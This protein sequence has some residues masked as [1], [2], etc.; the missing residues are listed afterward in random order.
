MN[1]KTSGRIP[2]FLAL[3]VLLVLAPLGGDYLLGI[4]S[5]ILIFAIFAMSLNLIVGYT[6]LLSFGHA[7]FFGVATYVVIGLG[8]H[9]GISGW[10]GAIAGVLASTALAAFIGMFCIRVK[11]IPFLMLTMAFSQLLFATALKWRS[12]TGGTDGLIGFMPPDFF[13]WNMGS[14]AIA[15]YIVIVI[16]FLSV[17]IFLWYL[18]RSP[19][20][21][22]FIG[23]RDNEQRMRAIG[24]P[25]QRFKLIAFTIAGCLA[26][27]GGSLYALFNSYVSSD[28]LH[29]HLSGDAMIMVI[30]GGSG[31]VFG[32]AFGAALFLLLKNFISSYN[33]YWAFWV[34]VIFIFCVMFLREGVWGLVMKHFGR[35][36][37]NKDNSQSRNRSHS[38]SKRQSHSHSHSHSESEKRVVAGAATG[39]QL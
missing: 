3:C 24:Y 17:L 20:G 18:V 22:I 16:G 33:E 30:L 13:G 2:G 31:T 6:G 39:E 35:L 23:I 32:P 34:G 7:A 36:F 28:I 1:M 19:L 4:V 21:S 15:R 25:V 11:G 5:E 26:G 12:V 29:W 37:S 9:L 38:E 10:L 14:D 27:I 8:V